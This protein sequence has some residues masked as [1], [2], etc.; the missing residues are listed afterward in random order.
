MWS[1]IKTHGSKVMT[2]NTFHGNPIGHLCGGGERRQVERGKFDRPSG[3]ENER[4]GYCCRK[5]GSKAKKC[6]ASRDMHASSRKI[7]ISVA[8]CTLAITCKAY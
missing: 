6:G 2:R 1:S 8:N 7:L 5:T 3:S 4:A